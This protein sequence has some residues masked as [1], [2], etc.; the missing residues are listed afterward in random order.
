MIKSTLIALAAS[1][2][3]V[4]TAHATD[5]SQATAAKLI[6]MPGANGAL[7]L[8][9]VGVMPAKLD[10]GMMVIL[11]DAQCQGVLH[12]VGKPS[13]DNTQVEMG[14]MIRVDAHSTAAR[15]LGGR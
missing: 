8:V 14:V 5:A 12:L 1:F 3:L 13:A 9:D 2:A 10:K 6:S 15:L 7:Q 11:C 4:A